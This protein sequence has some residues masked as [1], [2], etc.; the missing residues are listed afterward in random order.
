MARPNLQ[1]QLVHSPVLRYGLAATSIAVALGL[2]LLEQRYGFR[3]LEVP[4][5]LFAIAVTVWYAGIGP[6]IVAVVLS[7][8]AFDYFF[9]EPRF[10]FYIRTSELPYYAVFIAFALL[11]TWFSAVR[12]RV[13]QQLLQSRDKLQRE[14]VKRTQQASLLNLTH[15]TIF[16]RDMSDIISY[17]NRGA[18]ELYG[19]REEEAIGKHSHQLLQ[20][21]FPMP[22]EEVRAE[23]LRRR[24]PEDQSRRIQG[25]GGKPMVSAS[26]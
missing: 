23:L 13:E 24:A 7:S 2:A 17:W 12:R 8:L 10:S 15:D 9:T 11:L 19:W 5:F 26:R 18:E 1:L 3:D 25:G 16:V 20:T 6:A 21:E 14:V 22:I 4:L